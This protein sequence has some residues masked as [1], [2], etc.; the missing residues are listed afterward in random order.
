MLEVC[1]QLEAG[2]STTMLSLSTQDGVSFPLTDGIV[3][4]TPVTS[5]PA[6]GFITAERD[7][8]TD[9]CNPYFQKKRHSRLS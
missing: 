1:C 3:L 7:N 4:A 5:I 8:N 6:I 2:A 9:A